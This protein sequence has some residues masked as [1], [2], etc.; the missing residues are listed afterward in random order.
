MQSFSL[1]ESLN[2]ANLIIWDWNGTLLDDTL[3]NLECMNTLLQK[4]GVAPLTLSRYR[5]IFNFPVEDYY[6]VAGFDFSKTPFEVLSVE[7]IDMYQS[8]LHTLSLKPDSKFI[9]EQFSRQGKAQVLLSATELQNLLAQVRPHNI[10]HY[11]NEIIGLDNIHAES[12]VEMA[13]HWAEKH[14][15]EKGRTIMIGDTEHDF[16]VSQALGIPC[17]LLADGH[18][19]RE[20]LEKTGAP[21]L[22]G[23]HTIA[24]LYK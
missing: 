3:Y 10:E 20:R 9:L 1:K 23:L 24:E 7:F 15:I 22:D 8:N 11:F 2:S 5:E 12:K 21:V 19:S 13:V 4:Y 16:E 6:S 14:S 18:H 17:I